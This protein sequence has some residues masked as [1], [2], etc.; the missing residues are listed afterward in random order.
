MFEQLTPS[1][2]SIM[3]YD[4]ANGDFGVA[5]QSNFIAVGV[6]VPWAK[7]EVGAVATQASANVSYAPRGLD[8]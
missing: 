2:F 6:V 3:S 8:A 1:T 7:A 5:V 4:R